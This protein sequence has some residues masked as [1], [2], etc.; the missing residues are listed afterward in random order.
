[1]VKRFQMEY[2]EYGEMS[3][4][5][6]IKMLTKYGMTNDLFVFDKNSKTFSLGNCSTS[7]KSSVN[8]FSPSSGYFITTQPENLNI[9]SMYSGPK[10]VHQFNFVSYFDYDFSSLPKFCKYWI[11][12]STPLN[13]ESACSACFSNKS[14]AFW[15]NPFV[16]YRIIN[17]LYFRCFFKIFSESSIWQLFKRK[18]GAINASLV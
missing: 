18:R 12:L 8:I 3:R 9:K 15:C 13:G 16:W 10:W 4:T 1:M 5:Q 7:G 11:V 17:S 6:W 2:F 14:S